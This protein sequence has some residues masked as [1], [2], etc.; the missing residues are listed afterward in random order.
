MPRKAKTTEEFQNELNEKYPD[1]YTI[2]G[3]YKNAKTKVKIRYNK[4]GHENDSRP[5]NFFT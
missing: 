1:K 3:D 5:S 4:C 2:I